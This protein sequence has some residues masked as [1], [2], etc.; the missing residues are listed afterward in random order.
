MLKN[1]PKILELEERLDRLVRTQIDFQKEVLRIRSELAGLRAGNRIEQEPQPPSPT[2]APREPARSSESVRPKPEPRPYPQPERP[3]SPPTF[4]TSSGRASTGSSATSESAFSQYVSSYTESARADLEKFIGENLIS[5]IG[6]IVLVLG[7]GIGAKYAIDN[8]LISP[9]ARIIIGYI[10]GFGLVGLAIKLKPKYLNF[11]S[12]LISG[13]M[14]IMYFVTYFAYASYALMPQSA[15]FALM[16]MFTIFSVA[17]ALLYDRQVIAHIGLVGAYAVPFLLSDGSGNYLVLFAYMAIINAGIL[18]ISVKKYWKPLFYTSSGFTWLI[19][20]GWFSTKYSAAEHFYLALVFLAIFFAIFYATKIVH[21]VL[22]AE[23]GD[24]E[25]LISIFVTAFIFYGFC[26]AISDVKADIR[27]YTAFFTY[28]AVMSLAILI[29][30]YRFYG[31]V[32]VYL[33]YPFTWLIFGGWL[34]SNYR[35]EEHFYLAAIFAVVFFAVYYVATILYRL[36]ADEVQLIENSGLLLT[37]SFIFYGVGYGLIESRESLHGF[38]GIFTAAHAAMHLVV[39][40]IVIRLRSSAVD[41]VQVLTI[42]II[43]FA[44]ITIPVQFDGNYVT[45]MWSVEAALLFW[46]GRVK[47]IWLFEYFSYPIM[48]LASISL[49]ADW[50]TAY[51]ERTSYVSEFNRQP[52]ANGDFI[53]ALVFI[54]AFAFIYLTNR[55][56]RH[57]PAIEVDLVKPFGY[58]VAGLGLL[59]LYNTF[60]LEISNYYHVKSLVESP[61]VLRESAGLPDGR[62]NILWQ[63]NYTMFFLTAMWFVN[64]RKVRSVILAYAGIGFSLLSLLI[65]VSVGMQFFYELRESYMLNN[66]EL[67]N[68]SIRYISYLFAAVLLYTLYNYSQ[69]KMLTD[70]VPPAKLKMGY[71]GVVYGTILIVA[72]CELVNL[73]GQFYISDAYKLGL[74]VLWGIY[75]LALIVIGIVWSK[76]HL[77]IGAIVLLAVTLAKLFF[78]D[79]AELDTIPKTIL[80]IT[81]G[82]TMLVVSFLYNKY[83]AV[84]F[85]IQDETEE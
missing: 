58:I 18:A 33:S 63:L 38:A 7:V 65:F 1:D 13:G 57:E 37:N 41:V 4:S 28:L 30:S 17:A 69:D 31:R 40:Q 72:S 49:V 6:I 83:K 11:S 10:F 68:I 9:L 48:L 62:F 73:M 77:R 43:T 23:S 34:V 56:E 35:V 42:L 25:T 85:P 19:F 54:A 12:V 29:T 51:G 8:N 55:D 39:A 26:F 15:A 5:K 22:H 81:L 74:S 60:R 70:L 44:T 52:I 50:A 36:I 64:I 14:A 53:T 80:F 67:M 46:F 47:Q 32:L 71:D 27:E 45:L 59:V 82:I 76:K 75:A 78:Y 79:I 21:G 61:D 16:V 84:I 3:V 66:G 20:L 2:E 24:S